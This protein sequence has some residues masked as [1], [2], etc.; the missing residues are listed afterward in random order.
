[1]RALLSI[2]FK[3]GVCWPEIT[4]VRMSVCLF[5]YVCVCIRPPGYENVKWR[6]NNQS[7]KSYCFSMALAIDIIDGCGLSNKVGH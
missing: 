3:P 6:L 4:L 1:M 2:I 7:N 5:V